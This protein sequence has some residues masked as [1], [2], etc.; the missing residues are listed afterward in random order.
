MTRGRRTVVADP[1]PAGREVALDA[2]ALAEVEAEQPVEKSANQIVDAF[3]RRGVKFTE[4][5]FRKWVQLGLLPR[6]RRVGRKGKH[7]GSRGVYP[8]ST[9]RRIGAVKQLMGE[10]LTIEE[11]QRALRFK[12]VIE[13]IERS[14]GELLVGFELELSSPE[15]AAESPSVRR[16]NTRLLG[17]LKK[18][19]G[20]LVRRIEDL[21]RRVVTPLVRA[22]K[23][24]AFAAGAGGGAGEL[25]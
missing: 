14:L 20:E 2:R 4:A 7:Q 15:A 1:A 8:A 12:E 3:A 11:I 5:T 21:E 18:S 17:D 23:A 22:A 10:S 24:R 13:S 25:L 9:V 6:S 16:D 19:S